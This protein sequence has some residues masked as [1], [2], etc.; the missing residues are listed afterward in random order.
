MSAGLAIVIPARNEGVTVGRVVE[1][2][3]EVVPAA[4]VIVVDDASTDLTATEARAAGA[5]VLS[6]AIQLGAW[7]ATQ[8]GLRFAIRHGATQVLTMDADGQ[9]H[10]ESIEALLR[11]RVSLEAD[12]VIG[13]APERLSRPKR[14][15]RGYF[16]LIAG[17]RVRD[18][19]S[20]FRLYSARAA[21]LLCFRHA[22]LFDYQDLGVLMLL[23]NYGLKVVEARVPMS[24]RRHGMSRVFSSW[25]HV[26][27]Y[28]TLTTMI[29]LA[30]AGRARM[31]SA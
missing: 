5:T 25:G 14:I 7:G 2:V 28:M 27:R 6:L 20:G 18:F 26:A 31:A 3:R 16:E 21:R 29:V 12:L 23:K 17:I 24:E 10:A 11:A 9:H 22:T 4:H 15:A 1:Q 8:T 13:S 19:T 30:R